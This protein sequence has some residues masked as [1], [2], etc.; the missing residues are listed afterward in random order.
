M[1]TI[2]FILDNKEK[3]IHNIPLFQKKKPNNY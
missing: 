1:V 2:A 3:T